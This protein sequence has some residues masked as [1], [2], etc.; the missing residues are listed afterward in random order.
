MQPTERTIELLEKLRSTVTPIKDPE[1]YW[2]PPALDRDTRDA[3]AIAIEA[4][5]RLGEMAA[6]L[7]R[8]KA[9]LKATVP[10]IGESKE[11]PAWASDEGKAKNKAMCA[12]ALENAA[13]VFLVDDESPQGIN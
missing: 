8:V 4:V 13:N 6:E 11:G 5:K 12:K 9:I 1:R 3:L 2:N 7:D 10:W